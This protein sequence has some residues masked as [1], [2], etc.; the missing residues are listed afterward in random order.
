[1]VWDIAIIYLG[2]SLAVA[3]WNVGITKAWPT[4]FGVVLA[5]A[6]TQFLYVNFSAWILDQSRLPGE[7]S[8]FIGYAVIWILLDALIEFCI[9]SVFPLKRQVQIGKF[10]RMAG[11]CLGA[12]K[13]CILVLFAAA[14]SISSIGAPVPSESP[15]IAQ[16]LA[17]CTG[18]SM[19]MKTGLN[20]ASKLPSAVAS[21]IVSDKAP[22]YEVKFEEPGIVKVNQERV[23]GY[24]GLFRTLKS[25]ERL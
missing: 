9:A 7:L 15:P 20:A 10:N 23:D 17:E 14:A 4:P 13:A 6:I 19:I 3:G 24:R 22:S 2:I 5:T 16:W 21:R 8:F 1:M 25:L 18:D 11:A 12:V